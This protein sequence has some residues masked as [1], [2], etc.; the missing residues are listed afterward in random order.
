MGSKIK[1]AVK[2]HELLRK[3]IYIFNPHLTEELGVLGNNFKKSGIQSVL[4]FNPVAG[5]LEVNISK[6]QSIK[7][8]KKVGLSQ[9]CSRPERLHCRPKYPGRSQVTRGIKGEREE[10]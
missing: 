7:L 4:F 10:T 1:K 9:E 8:K 3:S 2:Y 5:V 6:K